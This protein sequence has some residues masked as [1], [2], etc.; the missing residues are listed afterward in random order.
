MKYL[1]LDGGNG[2]KNFIEIMKKNGLDKKNK[3]LFQKIFTKNVNYNKEIIRKELLNNIKNYSNKKI[4]IIVI[5][6]NAGS[7][8]ILDI[9]IKNDF[10]LNNIKIYEPIIPMCNY[11]IK[12][13]YKNILVMGTFITNN[14]KWHKRYINNNNINIKY[15]AFDTLYDFID[16]NNSINISKSLEKF[17][18][19]KNFLKISD[20]LV[21]GC[22]HYNIIKKD[23]SKYLKSEFNFKGDILDSNEIT[24]QYLMNSNS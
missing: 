7:S 22:T 12:K 2:G 15:L 18:K 17:R 6:C 14:I 16:N 19:Q 11:I 1:I 4:D 9:L 10:K 20:C 3:I 21:L 8:S 13:K 24:F 5:A 23:I